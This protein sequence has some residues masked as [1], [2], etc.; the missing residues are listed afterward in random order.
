M[1]S[2]LLL[3]G[4]RVPA[5]ASTSVGTW[6]GAGRRS[7]HRAPLGPPLGPW[8]RV[9]RYHWVVLRALT[10]LFLFSDTLSESGGTLL[11]WQRWRSR[12]CPRL[13]AAW[14]E[15][16]C[17]GWKAQFSSQLFW[18]QAAGGVQGCLTLACQKDGS[19][20]TQN[21]RKD[22]AGA[23]YSIGYSTAVIEWRFSLVTWSFGYREEAV[24]G[25]F[26]QL[27]QYS[28]WDNMRPKENFRIHQVIP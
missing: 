13:T 16:V 25:F 19:L 7:Q 23:Y 3:D 24:L 9:V 27:L 18:Y 12:L 10:A 4:L 17:Q 28:F 11:L 21:F 15:V 2:L 26:Q 8:R 20:A 1:G 5:S 6:L 14:H 22:E